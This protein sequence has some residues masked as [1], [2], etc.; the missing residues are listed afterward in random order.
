MSE[1]PTRNAAMD[2]CSPNSTAS[3]KLGIYMSLL[4]AAS[5]ASTATAQENDGP[6]GGLRFPQIFRKSE[7]QN[8]PAS[9][10]K[11]VEENRFI[12][13]ARQ[14]MVDARRFESLGQYD[15]AFDTATKAQSVYEA[16]MRTTNAEWP[17]HEQT[18]SEYIRDLEKRLSVI[19]R[20]QTQQNAARTP[21]AV[22]TS[23]APQGPVGVAATEPRATQPRATQRP[24][25]TANAPSTMANAPVANFEPQRPQPQR[26]IARTEAAPT[27][28]ATA[29]FIGQTGG[30][31]EATKRG[32][33]LLETAEAANEVVGVFKGTQPRQPATEQTAEHEA[34]S[35]QPEATKAERSLNVARSVLDRIDNLQTWQPV[36]GE[37]PATQ[38][39]DAGTHDS[40]DPPLPTGNHT[41]G[42]KA[43]KPAELP[44]QIDATS[45]IAD[46]LVGPIPT[47]IEKHPTS[48]SGP[49]E[50]GG[51][52]AGT[53]KE[54]K[55]NSAKPLLGSASDDQ[56]GT[57]LLLPPLSAE[58]AKPTTEASGERSL[59][60]VGTVQTISTFLGVLFAGMVLLAVRQL[61]KQQSAAPE[62]VPAQPVPQ[63]AAVIE[64]VQPQPIAAAPEASESPEVAE[65]P[66]PSRE[67]VS[68]KPSLRVVSAANDDDSVADGSKHEAE[69]VKSVFEQNVKLMESLHNLSD[70]AAA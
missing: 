45:G 36:S 68:Q 33:Q 18:P 28:A 50:I 2:R 14:L 38:P 5:L 53:P 31:L 34:A 22:P 44:E 47:H 62:A 17:T 41:A 56:H 4:V 57:A 12:A 27:E 7:A 42:G 61:L 30:I 48:Q 21:G 23:R 15:A 10:K 40:S 63:A 69:V 55:H 49:L 54:A 35:E 51:S 3:P 58:P 16:S 6:L 26:P 52:H 20:T 24:S 32:R 37:K 19:Q 43:S 65:E 8:P 11:P 66:L 46:S 60:L 59:W 25:T 70:S 13:R 67:A 1:F 29:G 64:E 9:A 39:T